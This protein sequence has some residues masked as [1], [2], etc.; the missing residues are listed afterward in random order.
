MVSIQREPCGEVD[1]QVVERLTLENRQGMKVE[2]LSYGGTIRAL[3][4]PDRDGKLANVVLGFAD[5]AGYLEAGSRSG[6]PYFGCIT[7]RFANRIA[8][9]VFTLDGATYRLALNDGPNALHGGERGFNARVWEA[10]EI[11]AADAAG[12]RLTRTSPHGEEGYPG[13]LDVAVTYL[14]DEENRLRIDYRAETDR[15]TVVN[16]TNHTYWNLAGEGSGDIEG[17]ELQLAASHYTPV[18]AT[19][20]PSGDIA[21]VAGTPFDFTTATT[22]G[23][24]LRVANPQL[25]FGQGYDHNFVFDRAPGDASLIATV[26]L[27]DPGS[28][29]LLTIW[30]TEPGVQVYTGNYLDGSLVGPSGRT[31]RQSDGIALETQHFP[32]SPN[33]PHFPSTVL[34]PGEVFTSTTIFA[35]S[36]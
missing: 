21:P 23:T 16:L 34:R 4:A 29:R 33:R 6:N 17:H 8:G 19:L 25:L 9:G 14:L 26:H 11:H 2:I 24:R 36:A 15:P 5:L 12:V 13:S 35:L 31:Y 30:T 18:D 7:G 27:H 1:G 22:I 32:D 20:N 10:E 28:G 3:W